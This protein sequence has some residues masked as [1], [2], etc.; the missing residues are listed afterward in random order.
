MKKY[1][2]IGLIGLALTTMAVQMIGNGKRVLFKFPTGLSE[3][4]EYLF[5]TFDLENREY[6]ASDTVVVRELQTYLKVDTLKGA[7]NV[8]L[9]VQPHVTPGATF[10]VQFGNNDTVRTAYIKQGTRYIDTISVTGNRIKRW[11]LYN[12]S[13]Y[14]KF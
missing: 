6:K 14:E 10:Y 7:Y 3:N 13:Y 12:G 4:R 1:L 9:N 8:V 11:Y 5:P 2:L